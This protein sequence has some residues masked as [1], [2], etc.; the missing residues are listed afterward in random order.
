MENGRFE[1][2]PWLFFGKPWAEVDLDPEETA[3]EIRH[4]SAEVGQLP[5]ERVVLHQFEVERH[6][7]VFLVRFDGLLELSLQVGR[8]AGFDSFGF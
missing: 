5:H 3:V 7:V 4:R 1:F 8:D 6:A 2:D